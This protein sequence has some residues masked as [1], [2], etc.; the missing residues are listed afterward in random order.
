MEDYINESADTQEVA[1]PET[2][3]DESAEN[4]EAAE[5]EQAENPTTEAEAP[6]SKG[7]GKTETDAAFAEMRR[8]NQQLEK[9]KQQMMKALSRYFDG[10][11]PEDL[12][13][14]AMAY[15][16]QRDPD[17]YRQEWEH[18]QEFE[19][20][21][22]TNESLEQE[23]FSLRAEKLMRDD[24]GE[25]QKIDPNIKSL[26]ELGESFLKLRLNNEFGLSATE[27]YFAVKAKEQHEKV[28]A[29]SAIGKVADSKTERDYY[30]SEEIDD[31]CDNRPELLDDDKVWD[32]VMRS[33]ERL[34]KPQ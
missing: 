22:T 11:T 15:A 12:S 10:D 25:I 16:D 23:L 24:L 28:L 3:V 5:P 1:E 7:S 8:Q 20:L 21:K 31:I 4:Q 32:K 17:E 30:T 29:P 6:E 26:D 9:E 18:D 33:M 27:A 13:I 34:N 19:K 14:N 2:N